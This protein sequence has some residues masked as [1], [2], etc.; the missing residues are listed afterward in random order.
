MTSVHF[1]NP[2]KRLSVALAETAAAVKGH[3]VTL[4]E[5]LGHVGEQGMLVFCAILAAPFLLPVGSGIM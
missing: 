5:L 1:R 4:R 3:A 2:E